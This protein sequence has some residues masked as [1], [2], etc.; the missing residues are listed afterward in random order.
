MIKYKVIKY[1][2]IY[3]IVEILNLERNY[4]GL[5]HYYQD[6]LETNSSIILLNEM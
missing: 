4:W 6:D 3:M 5:I 1:I 2:K